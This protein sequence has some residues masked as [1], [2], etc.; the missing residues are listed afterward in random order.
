[1]YS[2]R[3]LLRRLPLRPALP[4]QTLFR[5]IQT[6]NHLGVASMATITQAITNDHRDLQDC[7]NE[8]INST[9][10]DH[11]QRWGNQ[12]TWELARHSVGEELVLY[13]AFEKHMGS[14]GG[15]I[16][17][18]DRRDHH[19]VKQLLK[20]FQG[21]KAAN[22]DYLPKIKELWTKLEDH[23]KDE[24]GYDLPALENKLSP[25]SSESMANSFRRTKNF[26]P[27]RS[28]P[29]AGEHPPFETVMGLLTTPVDKLMD[30][31][32]KFPDKHDT[33]KASSPRV[34]IPPGGTIVHD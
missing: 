28:H 10:L 30:V 29:S 4:V 31:F 13:P 5:A 32:R 20:E 22:P 15:Q 23:I 16:A 2:T 3:L 9:D 26:V 14:L 25:D 17:E 27:S 12:F 1:M 24:E 18:T 33:P 19:Q 11:M 21:M 34:D 8:V 6:Q 7:Y